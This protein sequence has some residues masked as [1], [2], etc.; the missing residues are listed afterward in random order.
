MEFLDIENDFITDL[1]GMTQ[2]V[3]ILSRLSSLQ[4]IKLRFKRKYNNRWMETMISKKCPK[5]KTIKLL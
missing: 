3:Y 2:M 4:T 5:I 1:K